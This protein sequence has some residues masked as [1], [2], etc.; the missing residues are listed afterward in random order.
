MNNQT[1]GQAAI[2]LMQK[3][4]QQQSVIDTQREMQKNY[5]D[6]LIEAAKRGEDLFG[7][8]KPFYICVQNRRERLLNNVIRSQFY[9]RQTR[10]SPTYDLSLFWYEPCSENLRFVWCIP[11]KEAVENLISNENNVPEDHKQLVHFCKAFKAGT[12]I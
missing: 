8:T 11:D 1:V 3:G 4:D 2:D 9:P 7:K 6:N 12:L 10:P 5:V